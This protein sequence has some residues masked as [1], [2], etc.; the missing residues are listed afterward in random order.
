MDEEID[1]DNTPATDR[2]VPS[3]IDLPS[4]PRTPE[5]SVR[6]LR[7]RSFDVFD[8][9]L[10]VNDGG[11]AGSS[12]VDPITVDRAVFEASVAN[13]LGHSLQQPWESGVFSEIFSSDDSNIFPRVELVQPLLPSTAAASSSSAPLATGRFPSRRQGVHIFEQAVSFNSFKTKRFSDEYQMKLLIQRW[14][15]IVLHQKSASTTGRIMTDD[16]EQQL[17]VMATVLAGKGSA[18]LRKRA[19]QVKWFFEWASNNSR[20]CVFPLSTSDLREYFQFMRS[21]GKPRSRFSGWFEC[22]AFLQHVVGVDVEDDFFN[23]PYTTGMM[24]GIDHTRPRRKQSRPFTVAEI[25]CLEEFLSNP[26]NNIVDRFGAGC[27]LFV[28]FSRS[29]WG[30]VRQLEGFII[31]YYSYQP[32]KDIGYLEAT[33]ES[34][35]LR[36]TGNR[37]GLGLPLVA[38]VK[39]LGTGIW[40]RDFLT[41]AEEAGASLKNVFHSP[42]FPAPE[43][44]GGWSDRCISTKEVTAWYRMILSKAGFDN[45]DALTAHGCKATLLS[46]ASKY[47]M[48][49]D[50]RAILG[51]H[52]RKNQRTSIAVYSRDQQSAPIRRM[53]RMLL[54]IRRG[55]FL[56]DAFRSG[57]VTD[58]LEQ[59]IGEDGQPA[60]QRG[61]SILPDEISKKS[62]VRSDG[63]EDPWETPEAAHFET[64]HEAFAIEARENPQNV[65]DWG[66]NI[67]EIV[68][69]D[70]CW[71]DDGNFAGSDS[72]S[73][74]SSS[75]DSSSSETDVVLSK[76]VQFPP[77]STFEWRPQCD[78]FQHKKSKVIHLKPCLDPFNTFVC[79]RE[80]T[81]EYL[82]FEGIINMEEW[83][84][85]QC[86][87]GRPIRAIASAVGALDSA[88]KRV[89]RSS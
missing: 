27:I 29:R 86:D 62:P 64:L 72:G 54:D 46:M 63:Y 22:S 19:D 85:R 81:G 59:E 14:V 15:A 37:L 16:R 53:E 67:S 45:L 47:G 56:P 82:K 73:D 58:H 34:H 61:A 75:S 77:Q 10:E 8:V 40:G 13:G 66:P 57:M 84:C 38:P 4:S 79:G 70:T 78:V 80:L 52:M 11:N 50:D 1:G 71:D 42:L 89:R 20:G 87:G 9:S 12:V 6:P 65:I 24:R 76:A 60:S 30:D 69:N 51:Y 26:N 68:C 49:E 18:T 88:L 44:N 17:N 28:I 23:D 7:D 31:D 3:D 83:K 5:T 21:T 32:R 74:A 48:S 43:S 35:K 25:V 33:S 2:P 41:V 36:A 39:G 55:N